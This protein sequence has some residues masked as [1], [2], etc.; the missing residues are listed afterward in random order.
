VITGLSGDVLGAWFS[1]QNGTRNAAANTRAPAQQTL[2]STRDK[3]VLPPWDP[4]GEVT[5][6]DAVRRSVLG[7]GRFFDSD[8]KAFSNLNVS[9]DEKKLYAMSAACWRG[10]CSIRCSCGCSGGPRIGPRTACRDD[11][12]RRSPAP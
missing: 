3:D 4:R 11:P 10:C 7:N 6:L 12:R 9:Q 2:G 8:A 5:A 1:A